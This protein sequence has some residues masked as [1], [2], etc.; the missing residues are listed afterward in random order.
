[1]ATPCRF[2]SGPGHQNT[3]QGVFFISDIYISILKILYNNPMTIEE[4]IEETLEK[5][6]P[7]IIRD[8]GN[9]EF[10]SFIDGIIYIRMEGACS[11]CGLLDSTLSGGIEVIL[12]EEIPGVVAVRLVEEK[13]QPL[14][15]EIA[16][17]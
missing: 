4:Q 12:M 16:N 11:S 2:K 17:L 6:R 10:D 9:V 14:P 15:T 1:V 3:L 7:F 13:P 8:G 5:I